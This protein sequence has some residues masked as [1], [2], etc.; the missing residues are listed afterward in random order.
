MVAKKEVS[1]LPNQ[2]NVNSVGSRIL[3]WLTTVGR[4]VIV[5]T[6]L[7]VITAFISR[8]W[9]DRRSSDLSDVIR[10]QKAILET[11]QDFENQYSLLQQKLKTIKNFISSNP[12]YDSKINSLVSSTPQD[13]I[14]DSLTINKKNQEINADLTLTVLKEESIINLITN[15]TLNPDINIVDIKKVEKKPKENTYSVEV[16]VVFKNNIKT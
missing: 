2:E 3:K 6:E 11:T 9:L 10:Q 4:F 5:F 15:L 13:I 7:I 16:F 8:F 12:A 1:L 14:Y